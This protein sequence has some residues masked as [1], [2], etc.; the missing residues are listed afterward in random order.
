MN[1]G[2]T[3]C[4]GYH[5]LQLPSSKEW[6]L[7]ADWMGPMT[8]NSLGFSFVMIES[9]SFDIICLIIEILS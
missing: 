7:K 1:H 4:I 8:S 5:T 9:R 6:T 3:V 2:S